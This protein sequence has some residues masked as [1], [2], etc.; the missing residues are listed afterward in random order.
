MGVA[1]THS[2]LRLEEQNS[3]VPNVEIDE[4]LRLCGTR[5]LLAG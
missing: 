1:L 4:V 2:L 5:H 3:A